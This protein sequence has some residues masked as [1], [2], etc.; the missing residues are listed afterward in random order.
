MGCIGAHLLVL[1]GAIRTIQPRCAKK[2]H[3]NVE[4]IT[5]YQ[6]VILDKEMQKEMKKCTKHLQTILNICQHLEDTYYLQ[7]LLQTII[8]LIE[9]CFSLYLL[10]MESL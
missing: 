6:K 4:T 7:N 5:R 8:S 3:F 10:S 9:I 1:E 2:L